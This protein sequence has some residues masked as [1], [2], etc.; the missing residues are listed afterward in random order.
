MLLVN[1]GINDI[2]ITEDFA[3]VVIWDPLGTKVHYSALVA[4]PSDGES[5]LSH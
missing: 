2:R 1:S 3:F 4:L 5:V